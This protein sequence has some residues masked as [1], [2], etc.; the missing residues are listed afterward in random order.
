M[1]VI[2]IFDFYFSPNE[3]EEGLSVARS[4]GNDMPATEGYIG[5]DVIQDTADAG[6]VVVMTRWGQQSEGEA[7][8]TEYLHN[9]KV[10]RASE[11]LGDAPSGFL[12]AVLSLEA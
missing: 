8:L 2:S 1:S 11:L 3:T 4:I 6:H 12:G 10:A 7:V 5:H 9:P